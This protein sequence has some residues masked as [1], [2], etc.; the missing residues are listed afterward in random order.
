MTLHI[1][2][3][4]N[5]MVQILKDIFSDTTVGPFLGFKGGTAVYL[6]YNLPRFS[7]D[8]D[9]DIL[10]FE[11]R[12]HIFEQMKKILTAYGTIKGGDK[13]RD[14]LFFN[15]AYTNKTEGAQNI[16]IDMSSRQFGSKYEVKSYLGISMNVMVQEDIVAHKMSAM[17][18]RGDTT[19]RDIFDVW[20]FLKNN[21]PVN[22]EIIQKRTGLSYKDFLEE[23]I[24][25]L[26]A[27]DGRDM[28]SGLGE[29]VETEKQKDWVRTKLKPD[30]IFLLKLA[31]Q[32][33]YENEKSSKKI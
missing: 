26:E 14:G 12:D 27:T 3:H 9:F 33:E 23:S 31:Q 17:H 32:N 7:V 22:K 11:K 25:R 4:R 1:P 21:W 5:I 10:D 18:E 24:K 20:F 6:F 15:L 8:L 28:L 29:L 13:K 19:N 16:K 30:I 2:T